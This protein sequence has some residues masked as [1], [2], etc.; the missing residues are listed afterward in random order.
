MAE[1]KLLS[2]RMSEGDRRIIND[3][4]KKRDEQ[5]TQLKAQLLTALD[6]RNNYHNKSQDFK[7]DLA[8]FAGH[9]ASCNSH[10]TYQVMHQL[11]QPKCDCGLA[12]AQERWV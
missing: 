6:E 7:S 12:E 3:E 9:T 2:G 10:K 1:M 8:K 11:A 5:I 4:L